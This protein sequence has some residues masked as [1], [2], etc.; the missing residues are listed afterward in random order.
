MALPIL[1]RAGGVIGALSVTSTTVRGS[2]DALEALVP[3]I[4]ETAA[5]IA[6]AARDWRFPEG[7]D[8]GRGRA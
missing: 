7:T 8:Q 6:G 3:R 5:D 2:L 4:A 1:S